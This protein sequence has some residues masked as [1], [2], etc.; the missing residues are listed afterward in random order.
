MRRL[1]TG[2]AALVALILTAVP[3]H[4]Q[5]GFRYW[6]FFTHDGSQWTAAMTGPAEVI[7]D[8]GDVLGWRFAVSTAEPPAPRAQVSFDQVCGTGVPAEGMKRVALVLD[9]GSATDAPDGEQ[10]AKLDRATATCVEIATDANAQAVLQDAFAIR[11]ADSGLICGIDGYP[12]QGCGD[13]VSGAE[14]GSQDPI[15]VDVVDQDGRPVDDG[16]TTGILIAAGALLLVAV[17]AVVVIVRRRRQPQPEL[18]PQLIGSS[19]LSAEERA[20]SG[21]ASAD[22]DSADAESGDSGVTTSDNGTAGN[23]TR[24]KGPDGKGTGTVERLD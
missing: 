22:A 16:G 19:E 23:G 13:P 11:T 10:P 12:A 1:A 17:A 6:A 7:P 5:E 21:T 8:D 2:I 4:A 9:S 14:V 24:D 18:E 20:E 3:A 15:P